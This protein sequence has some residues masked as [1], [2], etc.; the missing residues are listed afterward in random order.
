M[1]GVRNASI[2]HSSNCVAILRKPE[3]SPRFARLRLESPTSNYVA[4]S[5][6]ENKRQGRS[7]GIH[8]LF[9]HYAGA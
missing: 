9:G 2:L 8:P 7:S 4:A 3:L 5:K 1:T 6:N